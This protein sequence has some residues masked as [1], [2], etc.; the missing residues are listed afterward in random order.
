MNTGTL[1]VEKVSSLSSTPGGVAVC[2]GSM[3]LAGYA[4]SRLE[5]IEIKKKE[6]M[7]VAI[8]FRKEKEAAREA[9]REAYSY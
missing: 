2:L 7:E 6:F 1:M 5:K 9:A 3:L 8:Q 4:I